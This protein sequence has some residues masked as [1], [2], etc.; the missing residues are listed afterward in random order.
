MRGSF[1][2]KPINVKD[3][4]WNRL[5]NSEL[6]A[7][8]HYLG[9]R[10]QS[11][12]RARVAQ[13]LTYSE[14]QTISDRW[15]KLQRA[16]DQC[17]RHVTPVQLE[18]PSAEGIAKA[19]DDAIAKVRGEAASAVSVTKAELLKMAREEMRAAAESSRPIVIKQAGKKDRKV[20]GVLPK[21]FDRIVQ[22]AASRVPI[23]MVGPAGCGKSYLGSKLA[24]A[25]GLPFYAQSCSEGISESVF[26][27]WLLPTGSGGAFVYVPAPFIT[28][29]EEGGVFLLDEMDAAD[30][31]LLAFLNMALAGNMF[32]LAQRFKKPLVKRHP[33]FV[34][35]AAANTF[36]A[37]ADA[38]YVG[39]NQL[40]EATLDRFRAG[41]VMMDYSDEVETAIIDADVLKWGRA[42]RACIRN[43]RM[44]RVM[45]TRAMEYFTRLKEEHG[46]GMA[47]W[48][49]SYF[50]AWTRDEKALWERG[51]PSELR[52]ALNTIAADEA[53][54]RPQ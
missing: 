6:A 17:V 30:P 12:H 45:S 38:M 11:Q 3:V 8:L 13:I 25:L 15:E 44:Q 20:T 10:P 23:M 26:T 2:T 54:R 27:G 19:V 53:A 22:L 33:D 40:D 35:I 37:G 32:F 14:N 28:A 49:E 51:R 24:E 9:M 39:R 7:V 52:S 21:V 43:N 1:R 41:M 16:Y 4:T 46:W 42:V 5:Q 29:Y 34:V 50:A 31:N 36:G 47:Q 48:E 18:V